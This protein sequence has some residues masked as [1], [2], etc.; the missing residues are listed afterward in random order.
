MERVQRLVHQSC[1]SERHLE[2]HPQVD[3][4][5]LWVL[6]ALVDLFAD[7]MVHQ[8]PLVE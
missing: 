2:Q 5:L 1:V 3:L 7:G 6:E 8:Y 4:G